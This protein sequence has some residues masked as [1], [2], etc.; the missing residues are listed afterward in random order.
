MVVEDGEQLMVF[1]RQSKGRGLVIIHQPRKLDFVPFIPRV[2]VPGI[3]ILN[4][5]TLWFNQLVHHFG[6]P[7]S[8]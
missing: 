2:R 1:G 8:T 7:V 4:F 6:A 5:P 3:P